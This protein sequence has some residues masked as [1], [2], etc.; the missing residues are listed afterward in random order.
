MLQVLTIDG[1]LAVNIPLQLTAADQQLMAFKGLG[2]TF[3]AL[4]AWLGSPVNQGRWL[5][6]LNE[7]VRLLHE[8]AVQWHINDTFEL[9]RLRDA[10]SCIEKHTNVGVVVV[11]P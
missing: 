6:V 8:G 11:V 7:A 9:H 2:V 5:H 10:I 1:R 4:H 3:M